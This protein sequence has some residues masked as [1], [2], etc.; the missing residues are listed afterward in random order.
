M[1]IRLQVNSLNF[2]RVEAKVTHSYMKLQLKQFIT[3]RNIS[4]A[5]I[6]RQ[7]TKL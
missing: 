3:L 2:L 7:F 6:E 4:I 5:N 1:Y